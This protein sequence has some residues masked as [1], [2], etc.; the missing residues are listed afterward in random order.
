MFNKRM[1]RAS[2]DLG[3]VSN[4]GKPGALISR[5]VVAQRKLARYQRLA[6]EK[7]LLANKAGGPEWVKIGI[8]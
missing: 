7:G 4:V 6:D 1:T 3:V 2:C 5:L 8:L